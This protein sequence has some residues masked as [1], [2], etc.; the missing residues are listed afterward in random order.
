MP[1]PDQNNRSPEPQIMM[2]MPAMIISAKPK[3]ALSFIMSR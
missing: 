1:V 3:K 2:I